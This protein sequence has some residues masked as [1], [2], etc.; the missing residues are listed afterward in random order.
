MLQQLA[1]QPKAMMDCLVTA[2]LQ[3]SQHQV[4]R[5]HAG[6]PGENKRRA[7]STIKIQKT[8][9]N[10][11][12]VYLKTV[13]RS[14]QEAAILIRAQQAVDTI[15]TEEVLDD[16]VKAAIL[17]TL[18]PCPEPYRQQ[19]R[20]VSFRSDYHPHMIRQKIQAN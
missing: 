8:I 4:V 2:H 20:K 7:Q 18:N 16:E 3:I 10:N 6:N 11:P 1:D 17:Q 9:D 19:L 15:H 5:D 12:K 13:L 14:D